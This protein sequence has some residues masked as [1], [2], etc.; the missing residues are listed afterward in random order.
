M[1]KILYF[2][3]AAVAVLSC[4]KTE[5][6]FDQ[7]NEISF[8]P[9]SRLNTKAA[10]NNGV[11]SAGQTF[12]VFANTIEDE[13]YFEN[14]HFENDAANKIDGS[15]I[16]NDDAEQNVYQVYKGNP[17]QYWPN[18]KMLKFAG[19]TKSGN[20]DGS[21]VK[22]V[23]NTWGTMTVT[24]YVQPVPTVEALND[25]MWFYD[26]DNGTGYDKETSYV[27][28]TMTHALSW[29]TVTV[30][31]ES[32]DLLD[33]WKNLK[34]DEIEFK[35]L[36]TGNK[37]DLTTNGAV[38]STD[39]S[40]KTTTV[41]VAI[42]TSASNVDKA[43][44]TGAKEFANVQNNTIVIPQTPAEIGLTYSYD[45]P[46]AGSSVRISETKIIDLSTSQVTSWDAGTH[47]T[48]ELTI[49]ATEI[50]IAPKASN[51]SLYDSNGEDEGGDVIEK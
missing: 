33:Y 50:K 20:I 51:W 5:V 49:G 6:A 1:K 48:Y 43:L 40:K 31:A 24:G 9:V 13:K 22:A 25:L 17:S 37:V 47:Y 32:Q 26:D 44:T 19:V 35:T 38:W 23:M 12:Y 39:D 42:L 4:T 18:I 34:I 28:P 21:T 41:D 2:A 14:I 16:V 36:V 3:I 46:A 10:V 8:S 7:P 45:S 27:Q 30:K 11:L 29:I 15:G